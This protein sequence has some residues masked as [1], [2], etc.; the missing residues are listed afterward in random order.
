MGC[1]GNP[2]EDGGTVSIKTRELEDR[3]LV[4]ISDNGLGF[5][6]DDGNGTG[7]HIGIDNIRG[8]LHDMCHGAL[9]VTSNPGQ[10]TVATVS[11]FKGKNEL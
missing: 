9:D 8:R 2:A 4:I 7:N 6:T 1:V 5:I 10:G 3:Y 11:I